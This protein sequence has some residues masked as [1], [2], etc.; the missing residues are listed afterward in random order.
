MPNM[1]RNMYDRANLKKLLSMLSALPPGK[2]SDVESIA[3]AL[4][5]V[6]HLFEG[7]YESAM[8]AHKLGRMESAE[9]VPP[10]FSFVI[11]RH[12]GAVLGSTR[13]E[14]QQWHFDL[15][16]MTALSSRT[17]KFRIVKPV[18]N[19]VTKA[20]IDKLAMELIVLIEG[21]SNDDR[22]KWTDQNNVR[23]ILSRVFSDGVKQTIRGRQK[24]L[25]YALIS[26]LAAWEFSE[27]N[28]F[29]RKPTP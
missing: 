20:D 4:K 6:W 28:K 22:L 5:S 7:S 14:L 2:V 8:A 27:P 25:K 23:V 3:T 26:R 12:G 16:K 29:T 19:S 10:N 15:E 13:A 9:W 18:A 11:E 24:R 1:P 17:G 21:H